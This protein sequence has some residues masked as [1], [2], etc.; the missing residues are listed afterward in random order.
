MSFVNEVLGECLPT[1]PF[2]HWQCRC[3]YNCRLISHT[4][5]IHLH[6]KQARIQ[7]PDSSL[8]SNEHDRLWELTELSSWRQESK[9]LEE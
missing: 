9:L 1:Q 4:I 2:L 8:S 3:K 7:S 5:I 6:D